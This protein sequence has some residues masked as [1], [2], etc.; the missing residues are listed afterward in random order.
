MLIEDDDRPAREK[1]LGFDI[2]LN[3]ALW[4]QRLLAA[5]VDG[6]F[7]L[8]AFGAFAAIFL[9]FHPVTLPLAQIA[10]TAAPIL[11][12]CWVAF[13]YLML[14]YGGTTPGL[15]VA[16]L[17]LSRFDGGPVPR[18]LR[19]WRVVATLLSAV[20]LGLGYAW[21]FLDEDALCWHDRIT[22]TYLAPHALV[23]PHPRSFQM[24]TTE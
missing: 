19:Q 9:K 20:S 12:A 6:V 16:K 14:V 1:R 18:R 3:S 17:R 8:A 5:T 4:S 2:P 13:K 10:A 15:R 7:V 21:F 22:R 23:C 11:A 24:L